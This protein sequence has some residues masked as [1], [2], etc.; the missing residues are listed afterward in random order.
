MHTGK[1]NIAFLLILGVFVIIGCISHYTT[2][3][4]TAKAIKNED[5]FTRG[6]NLSFNLCGPCHYDE[7]EKRFIGKPMHDLPSFMGK[8][9]SANLTHSS[10]YSALAKYTDA[11]V[12]YLLKTGVGRDGRYVPYM[13]RPNLA[14][15]DIND[16]LIYLRSGDSAVIA[17]DK[18]AGQT[19][20]NTLG[21]MA[22]KI[23]G[24]PLPYKKGVKAPKE[25]DLVLYGE[26]LVDNMACYHCHSKSILGLDY[27]EP[28]KSKGYM[29]GGMR[30]KTPTGKKI[31]AANLTPD[32]ETGIGR[33][34]QDGFR[35]AIRRGIQPSGDSLHLPMPHFKHL[36]DK[37]CDA[38]YTY[39][40]NLTPVKN[41]IKR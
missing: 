2:T 28:E 29:Q 31:Y 35:N 16:I 8:V 21:K 17:T 13:I 39:L 4:E 27:M 12:H 38:I 14:D 23:S 25:D 6:K 9:Y 15:S 5:S 24:K 1:G 7:H 26:Y 11:E 34:T 36:S 3:A 33:Y 40:K 32:A 20:I 37:Q 10:K 22:T 18:I 30:F 41:K 19:K